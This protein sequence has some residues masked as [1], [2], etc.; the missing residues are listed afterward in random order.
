MQCCALRI[1]WGQNRSTRLTGHPWPFLLV[2]IFHVHPFVGRPGNCC[3]L[4]RLPPQL[5]HRIYLHT[6]VARF[7]GHPYT[8]YLDGRKESR[9]CRS[10]FDPPPACNFAGLLLSCRSLYAEA[11]ALPYSANQFVIFYSHQGSLEPLRAL[12]PTSIASMTLKIVFNESSC[13][14]PVG[15]CDYPPPCCCDGPEDKPWGSR[16]HCVQ[17]HSSLHSR[18]LFNPASGLDLNSTKLAVQ[19]ML[20]EWH[21]TAAYLSAFVGAGCFT[22]L[23]VCDLNPQYKYAPE[24]AQLAIAPLALFPPL[25]DCSIRLCKILNRPLQRLAEEAVLQACPNNAS[26][27]CLGPAKRSAPLTNLPPEIRLRILEYTDLITPW[28]EVTWG[29]ESYGYQVVRPP[30]QLTHESRCPPHILNGCRLSRCRCWC[31]RP[32]SG[33]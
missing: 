19:A 31:D 24:A 15:S 16:Y 9:S 11:A 28:K 6:G 23:L 20:L 29:R 1:L 21:D 27:L 26:P 3:K 33:P 5:H 30:C 18:P 14:Y 4:L 13:H 12:S 32:G 7:D 2:P 17:R 10:D 22:L 25:K 8:Y